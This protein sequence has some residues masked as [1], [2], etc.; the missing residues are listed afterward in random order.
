MSISNRKD[1]L[2]I[3]VSAE[4]GD[5]P[6]NDVKVTIH[7][8]D[9]S[10]EILGALC[11]MALVISRGLFVGQFSVSQYN[12]KRFYFKIVANYNSKDTFESSILK[13]DIYE[14][15]PEGIVDEVNMTL[16]ELENNFLIHLKSHSLSKARQMTLK[17]A[18]KNPN[19]T[20]AFLDGR[21]LSI[22]YKKSFKGIVFLDDPNS[23]P[24]DRIK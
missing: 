3:N 2:T 1:G 9:E 19:I 14:P 4:I 7:Q 8:T 6:M 10:G 15:L 20:S 18:Q 13:V 22:V 23:E 17:E 24:I 21:N 11:D 12:E 16:K 5:L